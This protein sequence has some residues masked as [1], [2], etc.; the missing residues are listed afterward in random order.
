MKILVTG[1]AGFI[2]AALTKALLERGD[3][4]IGV[5]N[6]NDYYDVALKEA[7]LSRFVDNLNYTHLRLDISKTAEIESV[8]ATHRPDTVVNLAAQAGVRYSLD[9]PSAYIQSNIVGFA[10]ILE[11]CRKN[12]VKHLVYASSSSVYGANTE[13]PFS[14]NQNVDHPL[15]LYAAT[16]KSNE[17]MAHT[18]SH[19]YGLPTTGLRLFTVY[20]PWGRPD[21]ALFKFTKQILLGEPIQIYNF[22]N[23]KRDFTFIDDAVRGIICTLDNPANSNPDWN[24][25]SPSPSSSLAPYKVYNLGYG[26][27]ITLLSFIEAIESALGEKAIKEYLPAQPGDIISTWSDTAAFSKECGYSPTTTP[28]AGVKEFVKWYTNYFNLSR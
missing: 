14:T 24:G 20:G 12:S 7:R 22:G 23:H 10:N 27:P 15:S 17:L 4:V 19:L 8:F 26:T 3:V 9:N 16:K 11:G 21:M 18:Y 2:G 1:S 28:A 25:Y 13:F 5:D 6:H